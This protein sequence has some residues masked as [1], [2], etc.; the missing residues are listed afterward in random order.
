[1]R[2]IA[3]TL[4]SATAA[5]AL[6]FTP[7]LAQQSTTVT[8]T[9]GTDESIAI[10]AQRLPSG[11]PVAISGELGASTERDMI[12]NRSD[13]QV[14]VSLPGAISDD[15]LM[16]GDAVTAYGPVQTRGD[17][18]RVNADALLVQKSEGRAK[19]YLRPSRLE[20]A[21]K[22]NAPVTR[23][24]ARAALEHFEANNSRL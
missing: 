4:L 15:E 20:M 11:T 13:G 24:E 8:V 22:R 5:V 6:S 7:S 10:E 18:V 2:F 19:L 17:M 12:L 14:Y 3:M 1:M 16:R 9:Q 23:A 21:N